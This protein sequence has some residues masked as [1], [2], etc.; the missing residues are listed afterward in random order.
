MTIAV[1][2]VA[3]VVNAFP[4]DHRALITWGLGLLC[5]AIQW[6]TVRDALTIKQSSSEWDF[7]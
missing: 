4:I 5:L 2:S 6:S 3:A 7:S 1:M